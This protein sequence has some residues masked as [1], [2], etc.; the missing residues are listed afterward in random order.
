MKPLAIK[1][2]PPL[3]WDAIPPKRTPAAPSFDGE[4]FDQAKDGERLGAQLAAVSRLMQDGHWRTP[5][6]MERATGYG[7]ASISARLRDLRK[8][9]FGGFVVERRRREGADGVFEY[10]VRRQG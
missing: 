3:L 6:D 5:G 10:R 9:R 8:P 1:S 4:T 7:W 2:T